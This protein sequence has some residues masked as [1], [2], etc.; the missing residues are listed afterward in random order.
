MELHQTTSTAA[1]RVPDLTRQEHIYKPVVDI[2]DTP[3]GLQIF[4]DIP[5]ATSE[6]IDLNFEKGVLTLTA[7]VHQPAKVEG[8]RSLVREYGIGSYKRSFELG[9]KIDFE[10]ATAHYSAGVLKLTLPRM[11]ESEPKKIAVQTK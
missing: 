11:K 1:N 8:K 6:G 9:Q 2:V 4:A 7:K 3:E 10:R 5:G